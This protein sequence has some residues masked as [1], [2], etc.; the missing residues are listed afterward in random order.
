LALLPG[1][2]AQYITDTI[3][4][5]GALLDLLEYNPRLTAYLRPTGSVVGSYLAFSPDGQAL[6]MSECT[7]HDDKDLCTK[8]EIGFWDVATGHMIGEPI[9]SEGFLGTIEY[10]PDGQILATIRNVPGTGLWPFLKEG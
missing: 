4:A 10:S 1:V 6:A 8:G 3:E 5:R 9:P 7:D 2:H